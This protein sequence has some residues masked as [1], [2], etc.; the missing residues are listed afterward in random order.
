M[1]S[2]KFILQSCFYMRITVKSVDLLS[3]LDVAY[4][5]ILALDENDIQFID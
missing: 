1:S 4:Q 2:R 5:D 3:K